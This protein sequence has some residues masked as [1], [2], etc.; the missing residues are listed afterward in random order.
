MTE[1]QQR[2]MDPKDQKEATT[3]QDVPLED[4]SDLLYNMSPPRPE[5]LSKQ[6]EI[7]PMSQMIAEHG[8]QKMAQERDAL[9]KDYDMLLSKKAQLMRTLYPGTMYDGRRC[10]C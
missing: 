1:T 8:N 4:P 7:S 6:L 5:D 3:R 2:T 10:C 9:K